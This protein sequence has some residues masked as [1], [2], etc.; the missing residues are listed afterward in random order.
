[1]PGFSL[2]RTWCLMATLLVLG[3][4][5]ELAA[6]AL[7][8]LEEDD[9]LVVLDASAAALEALERALRDPRVWYQIGDARVVPLPDRSV[10]AALGER[11]PDVER[12]LR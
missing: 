3:A 1:V 8:R 7:A 4:D 5:E 6:N 2:A 9:G 12:V 11:S 10:D